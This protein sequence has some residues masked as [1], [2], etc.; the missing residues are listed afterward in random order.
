MRFPALDSPLASIIT[1]IAV[2]LLAAVLIVGVAGLGHE[3]PTNSCVP[4]KELLAEQ[5]TANTCV[6]ASDDGAG[7]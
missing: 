3:T 2:V 5:A 4:S 6:P 1:I 7:A